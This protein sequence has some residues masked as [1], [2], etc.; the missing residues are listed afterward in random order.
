MENIIP[1]TIEKF[2]WNAI[3]DRLLL[4]LPFTI[5]VR[6]LVSNIEVMVPLTKTRK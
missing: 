1:N 2:L 6:E 4:L 3:N 5:K